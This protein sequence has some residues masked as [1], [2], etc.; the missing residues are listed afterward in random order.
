MAAWSWRTAP[1]IYTARLLR[2]PR[3]DGWGYGGACAPII[4]ALSRLPRALWRL[5]GQF[6]DSG[7]GNR[8]VRP[9]CRSEGFWDALSGARDIASMGCKRSVSA[10]NFGGLAY[11]DSQSPLFVTCDEPLFVPVLHR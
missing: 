8:P 9:H 4:A 2:E 11:Y 5:L 6:A 10:V 1:C 7:G 3:I